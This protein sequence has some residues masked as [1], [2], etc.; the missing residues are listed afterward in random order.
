MANRRTLVTFLLVLPLCGLLGC[1]KNCE[2]PIW[3]TI[4]PSEMGFSSPDL[5]GFMAVD[6]SDGIYVLQ[7]NTVTEIMEY[8]YKPKGGNWSRHE[9]LNYW[10]ALN[11]TT[12]SD[13]DGTVW[14]LCEAY[15]YHMKDGEIL[16][17]YTVTN[18]SSTYQYNS[19]RGV[20][21]GGGRVWLLNTYSGLYE[22]IPESGNLI[23]YPD[24][25]E[26]G[27]YYRLAADD[28]GNVWVA[29]KSYYNALMHLDLNRDWVYVDRSDPFF[30]CPSCYPNNENY[31]VF[32]MR[33]EYTPDNRLY[34]LTRNTGESFP[35]MIW[36]MENDSLVALTGNIGAYGR[37]RSD[38][39]GDVW[40]YG[41]S[42]GELGRYENGDVT[43]IN[44]GDVYGT[45]VY[46]T[47]VQFDSHHNMWV[48]NYNGIA[49]YNENG[50]EY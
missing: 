42:D 35:Y 12:A 24:T 5:S 47:D 7:W 29:K 32:A 38:P 43:T 15:L 8:A 1:K 31:Y 46:T 25:S 20:S 33:L 17:Q 14:L 36:T 48:A 18:P 34:L 44:I 10:N 49:V 4:S 23:H 41:R 39:Y 6:T 21:T 30:D 26:Q 22:L 28:L 9:L 50:V 19:F 13:D 2:A 3:V 11:Y 37:L 40:V 16:T 45:G 27:D